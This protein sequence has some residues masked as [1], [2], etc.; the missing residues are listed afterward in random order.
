MCV[1]I[2]FPRILLHEIP[3]MLI[4]EPSERVSWWPRQCKDGSRTFFRRVF[5][6]LSPNLR[7]FNFL[8]NFMFL[9]E[10]IKPRRL[11]LGQVYEKVVK[12]VPT[13]V[14]CKSCAR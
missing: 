4:P 14:N 13:K 3:P 1:P 12:M 2:L 9:W 6:S 5:D 11:K 10:T 8:C 7:V